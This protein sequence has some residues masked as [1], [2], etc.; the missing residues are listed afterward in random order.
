MK[1]QWIGR[2]Y[3]GVEYQAMPQN[4]HKIMASWC[5]ISITSCNVLCRIYLIDPIDTVTCIALFEQV[6]LT[7]RP[8]VTLQQPPWGLTA[9]AASGACKRT[10]C[11]RPSG[12]TERWP[13]IVAKER[14]TAI[15]AM[16]TSGGSTPVPVRIKTSSRGEEEGEFWDWRIITRRMWRSAPNG[17][18]AYSGRCGELL[19]RV[20]STHPTSNPTTTRWLP[21]RCLYIYLNIICWTNNNRKRVNNQKDQQWIT[22]NN[23]NKVKNINN[24]NK[25]VDQL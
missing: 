10:I 20:V 19:L 6:G 14:S 12:L 13:G 11:K 18:T 23:K 4:L 16:G 25:Y 1:H 9:V 2:T 5:D 8:K 24:K 15:A 17:V 21:T 22:T 7:C 3:I